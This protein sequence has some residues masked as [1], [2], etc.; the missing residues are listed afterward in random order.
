MLKKM[1]N[2]NAKQFFFITFIS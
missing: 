2:K 1:L